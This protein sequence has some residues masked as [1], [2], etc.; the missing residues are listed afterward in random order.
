MVVLSND[1]II[2][3]DMVGHIRQCS[4]DCK[5]TACCIWKDEETKELKSY[6]LD[7]QEQV[8]GGWPDVRSEIPMSSMTNDHWNSII[9]KCSTRPETHTM[10]SF[11]TGDEKEE[12][13]SKKRRTQY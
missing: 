7:C 10:P 11:S 8:F 2:K 9:K 5:T 13:I 3:G 4:N 6:C 1:Q 12:S